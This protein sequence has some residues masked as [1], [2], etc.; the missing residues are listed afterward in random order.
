MN[1]MV[2]KYIDNDLIDFRKYLHYENINKISLDFEGEYNLHVYGEKLCLIQIFDGKQYFIIDPLK[3]NDE[4]IIEFLKNKKIVKL[5]YGV[6]S[7]VSLIYKQYGVKLNNVF[8]QK[9]LV[10][11][12]N[13]ETKS[14]DGI[15]KYLFNEEIK[16]KKKYQMYNWL[17][18]PIDKNAL[19]YALNDVKY[20][21]K[22]N[23][24]LMEKIIKNNMYNEL[25]VGIITRDFDFDKERMPGIFKKNEFK[26][27]SEEQKKE[28]QKIFE[29]RETFAK[30]LNMPPYNILGNDILFEIINKKI[31]IVNIKLNGRISE[32]IKNEIIKKLTEV[33]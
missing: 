16:D 31:A 8:D 3:I 30:S 12:L 27:L 29:I 33:T 1:T 4:V 17:K 9:I 11:T 22:I 18:R 26:I 24:L 15:I 2:F 19:Q 28:F 10:D 5:M 23:E 32:K 20:L 13:I 21:F 14:L 7:D 6:E 25:I